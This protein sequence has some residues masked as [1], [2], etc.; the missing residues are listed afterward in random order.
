MPIRPERSVTPQHLPFFHTYMHDAT[1]VNALCRRAHPG[2]RT[3]VG[4]GSLSL[5]SARMASV[6]REA[7]QS[8]D[9]KRR[10]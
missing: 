2:N 5:Q 8:D 4:P 10:V 1:D 3:R 9:H 7:A 6:D